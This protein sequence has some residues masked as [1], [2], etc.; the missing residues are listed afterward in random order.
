MKLRLVWN[1]SD[2]FKKKLTYANT[3]ETTK[4]KTKCLIAKTYGIKGINE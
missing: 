4:A 3:E 1:Q 2:L